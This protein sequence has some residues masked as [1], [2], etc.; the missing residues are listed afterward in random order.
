MSFLLAFFPSVQL[1]W[2]TTT[3]RPLDPATSL[4]HK[5]GRNLVKCLAQRH[6]KQACR[7]VLYPVVFVLSAKQGSGEYHF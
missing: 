5:D 1:D 2:V 7:F 3:S 4:P 6:N